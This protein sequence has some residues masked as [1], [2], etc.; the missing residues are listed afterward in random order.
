MTLASSLSPLEK[1]R[2]SRK[3]RVISGDLG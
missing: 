1:V 3:S 2:I